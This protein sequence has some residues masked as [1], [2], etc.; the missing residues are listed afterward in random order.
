M[1]NRE[2]IS[3]IELLNSEGPILKAYK[4]GK[5]FVV[6]DEH[7]ELIGILKKDKMI[8]F[9]YDKMSLIDS[10]NR[11]FVYGKFPGSMKPDL[12]KLAEFIG[13]DTEGMTF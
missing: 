9:I 1:K 8:D 6:Q 5:E 12:R 11:L 3:S 10:K 4:I 7:K 13:L 2:N